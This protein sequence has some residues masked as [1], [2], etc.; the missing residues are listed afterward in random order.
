M[1][2]LFC[3]AQAGIWAVSVGVSVFELW[4]I[5]RARVDLARLGDHLRRM[6]ST[7]N[8]VGLVEK[9][10]DAWARAAR[11]DATEGEF[12][13][14]LREAIVATE[15]GIDRGCA[16]LR[17]VG[18]GASALGFAAVTYQLSWLHDDHGLLDLDPWRVARLGAE[19]ATVALALALA[20]SGTA[21]T[22][23]SWLGARVA[24]QRRGIRS[25]AEALEQRRERWTER[26]A[27]W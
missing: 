8:I 25:L 7:T 24:R 9:V 15:R 1:F 13:V 10:D 20:A 23:R 11:V 27:T 17:V 16:V 4:R 19:R 2:G 3:V 6:P 22:S 5:A 14:A 12:D 21:A 26:R 18:L